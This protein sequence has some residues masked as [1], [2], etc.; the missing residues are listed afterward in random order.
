MANVKSDPRT[1]RELETRGE[2]QRA[3]AWS[4][5]QLLPEFQKVPGWSYRWIR[6]SMLGQADAMNVSSKMR[7]GWEPVQLADHPEMKLLATSDTAS[8]G[9]IEI[10][11]LMLCKIPEEFMK[12]RD[13][14][15]RKLTQD[16]TNA[17]DN[18]FMKESDGRM[19]LFKENKSSTSFGSGNR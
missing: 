9:T 2:F 18:N 1:P 4:P 5:A 6:T 11:G 15:Y 7:E 14:H 10:G 19:P 17:I 16:Q 3:A 13:A 12:Q 8:K